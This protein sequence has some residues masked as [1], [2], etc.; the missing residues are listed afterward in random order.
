ELLTACIEAARELGV[1][2]TSQKHWLQMRDQL[3]QPAVG[4]HGQLLEW[5]EE[6]EEVE[7]GHRHIS[8]LFALHPGTRITMRDTPE[9][10]AACRTTL[11]RRLASGGGHTGWSR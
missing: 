6:Y 1:D 5:M 3:P 9:W 11:E 8:H 4:K 7:P 10:A 2:V